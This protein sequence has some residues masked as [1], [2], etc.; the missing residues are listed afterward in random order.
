MSFDEGLAFFRVV[1][2]DEDGKISYAELLE[3]LT[4]VPD[5]FKVNR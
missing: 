2:T 3:A 5:Y 1:D 4:L